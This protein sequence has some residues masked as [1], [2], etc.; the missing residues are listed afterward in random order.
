MCVWLL[1][2]IFQDDVEQTTYPVYQ[3][4]QIA[5][6][7]STKKY[8]SD[9]F[10]NSTTETGDV[11]IKNMKEEKTKRWEEIITTT[12][13]THNSRKHGRLRYLSNH[14]AA[15]TPPCLVSANQVARQQQR[16]DVYQTY[17]HYH[18]PLILDNQWF[19]HSVKRSTEETSLL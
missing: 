17:M 3:R 12:N 14:P 1:E 6:M 2:G 7:K 18:Q 9:P 10:D 15:S 16:H 8:A 5:C 11:L 4:N 13:M 19:T